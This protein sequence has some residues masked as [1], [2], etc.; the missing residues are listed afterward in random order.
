M[1]N[2][3]ELSEIINSTELTLKVGNDTYI[4]LE[5]LDIHIGRIENRHATTDG[6]VYTY[7][8]GDNYFTATLLL[9]GPELTTSITAPP[10][11]ETNAAGFN[12]LSQTDGNGDLQTIQWKIVA[13]DVSGGTKTFAA[14]GLLRDYDIKK[15]SEG[16]VKINI[17]VRITGDTI[18]VS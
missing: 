15:E 14:T 1:A 10:N 3:G 11:D 8:K 5:N 12:V 4:L 6:L 13:K 17:F 18:T 16:V 2:L 9:T 7:G